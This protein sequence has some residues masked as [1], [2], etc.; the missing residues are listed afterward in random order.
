[1]NFKKIL[2]FSIGPIGGAALGMLLLPFVAWFFSVEDV[3]RLTLLQVILGLS[4]SLLS[5]EMHQAYVREYY[6][7][8]NKYILFKAT[9]TPG[10]ILILAIILLGMIQPYSIS[11]LVFGIDSG[12]ITTF[13]V[14]GLISVFFINL[15][16]HV[17][18]MQERGLAFSA[19]QILPKAFLL[20]FVAMILVF[21]LAPSFKLL[22]LMNS[23][24][25][26]ASLILFIW[27]TRET[28]IKSIKAPL[29][30][31]LLKSMLAFSSP[32]I[33]GGLAYWGLTT[34]D[35]IFLKVLSGF[36]ELGVY[37][38]SVSLAGA[39][40]VLSAIFSN[41]WHPTIYKWMRQ[42]VKVNKIQEIAEFMFIAVAFLWSMTGSFSWVLIYFLPVEYKAIQ[43]L[44]IACVSMPLFYI[45]SETTVVGININKKTNYA[46]FASISAFVVNAIL[47]Y[48]L[49]PVFGASGAALASVCAFFIFFVLRTEF[50][51][52]LWLPFP[53]FK[54]YVLS[55]LYVF[56]TCVEVLNKSELEYFYL[57]W[58]VLFLLTLLLFNIRTKQL[59][60]V[61][62]DFYREKFKC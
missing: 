8:E 47:N 56:F 51:A 61:F 40:T 34:M 37:A 38:L 25:L 43:Y 22:M 7:C 49:I 23:L 45:L 39:L 24:S 59:Y 55:V 11:D 31:N 9:Y 26:V 3:G 33:A 21:N 41:L 20:I 35:R 29:D 4:F 5:L 48:F 15:L 53:R 54:M 2:Q 57:I 12:F 32:L 30:K 14:I 52:F 13:L 18:R 46:M 16:A 50:S 19:T 44:I 36:E 17:V 42:G 6:E 58:I 60:L 28:V 10:I 62:Y 1:M 27:L